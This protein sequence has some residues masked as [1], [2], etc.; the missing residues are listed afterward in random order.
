MSDGPPLDALWEGRA[1]EIAQDFS[2]LDQLLRAE[3]IRSRPG[4]EGR[5]VALVGPI[6][7]E[8]QRLREQARAERYTAELW[9]RLTDLRRRSAALL[10]DHLSF[11]GAAQVTD[12][13]SGNEFVARAKPWLHELTTNAGIGEG[14]GLVL[15][16]AT[17][18]NPQLRVAQVHFL[19]QDLWHL[20]LL[21]RSVGLCAGAAGSPY[22]ND[23][24]SAF[25]R[26]LSPARKAFEEGVEAPPAQSDIWLPDLRRLLAG[27]RHARTD[28]ARRAYRQD[29]G[30][31]LDLLLQ[32]QRVYLD[33]I[34]A[35]MLATAVLGP[36]Y[37][38]AL[39]A[40]QLDLRQPGRF[41]PIGMEVTETI[42]RE[43]VVPPPLHRFAACVATLSAIG[44][45]EDRSPYRPLGDAANGLVADWSTLERIGTDGADSLDSVLA[46]NS[47]VYAELY[48]SVIRTRGGMRVM[49]DAQIGW[50]QA[51]EVW[52]DVFRQGRD[53]PPKS[54]LTAILNAMWTC[55]LKYP[56]RWRRIEKGA[57][58][59]LA[60]LA[61]EG[62]GCD[63]ERSITEAILRIR[64]EE[65][66]QRTERLQRLLTS[67]LGGGNGS[68]IYGRFL[69]RYGILS[70]EAQRARRI[71]SG[72]G[73]WSA[74]AHLREKTAPVELEALEVLGGLLIQER[75]L[76]RETGGQRQGVSICTLA[77]EILQDLVNRTGIDWSGRVVFG[78]APFLAPMT[79][80]IRHRFPDWSLWGLPLLGHEFGHLVALATPE[81]AQLK[82]RRAAELDHP[83]ADPEQRS[84]QLDEFFAD[85]FGLYSC[86]PAFAC[87]VLL[88]QLNPEEAHRPRG[89]H[90]SHGER[91]AM[92]LNHLRLM[93][94][95][96]APDVQVYEAIFRIL[97]DCWRRS[98][99][100]ARTG[101]GAGGEGAE[102]RAAT[103]SC[104]RSIFRMIDRNHCLGARYLPERWRYSVK[105]AE[106]LAG[107]DRSVADALAQRAKALGRARMVM[108]LVNALWWVR[109]DLKPKSSQLADVLA[110]ASRTAR[111][112]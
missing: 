32:Q 72:R 4:I 53:A 80:V 2:R 45:E 38:R 37:P 48:R 43:P 51:K 85:A 102:M 31:R 46:G 76:D 41:G 22:R 39:A 83:A 15:G 20:P 112:I 79:D 69:R 36:V 63:R 87:N 73:A 68:P 98:Q 101:R 65:L 30:A 34:F 24:D 33:Q 12:A 62:C 19:D 18:F 52:I 106:T 60:G 21:G 16:R 110:L 8:L 94:D 104:A 71:E 59:A 47:E 75:G 56:H 99:A 66:G 67:A 74:R 64:I 10:E 13:G 40:L 5:F 107:G 95:R 50:H 97:D 7:D 23:L 91:A 70:Y 108:D 105:L 103:R 96:A 84:R 111:S 9:G 27:F 28:E 26:I 61:V 25:D 82:E 109:L 17:Q 42:A 88:L 93:M 81:L 6:V 57:E 77:E 92:V 100:A 86:G 55:R 49:R 78:D 29:S 58:N 89:G 35:D 11:L 14:I 54:T 90:P 44:E 3:G 1:E